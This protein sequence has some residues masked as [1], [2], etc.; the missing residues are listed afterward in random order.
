MLNGL[1]SISRPGYTFL[2]AKIDVG[3]DIL[4]TRKPPRISWR[5][6][7]SIQATPVRYQPLLFPENIIIPK[8][9]DDS[10]LDSREKLAAIGLPEDLTGKTVMDIGGAEG[11]FVIQAALRGA[12]HARGCDLRKS[13]VDIARIV[14]KS[15]NVEDRVSFSTTPL[16]DIPA[17]WASD[18]VFCLSVIHHLHGEYE[19]DTWQIITR[20]QKHAEAFE[21]MLRAVSSVAALTN[22]VTYFEY[23]FLYKRAGK[24]GVDHSLLGRVWEEHGFYRKVDFIDLSHS[25]EVAG[26]VKDRAIY[27][28]WK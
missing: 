14:A 1:K 13:R 21:N 2:K 23:A 4:K 20:P 10:I 18:I 19:H 7:L 26:R 15:W 5:E 28:A 12:K 9:C 11:F 27:H 22:E 17:E 3:S 24:T 16:H 25:T 6:F 8:K